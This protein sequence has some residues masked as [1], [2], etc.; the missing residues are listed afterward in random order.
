MSRDPET[1]GMSSCLSEVAEKFTCHPDE[2]ELI[3][4]VLPPFADPV[5]VSLDSGGNGFGQI[6]ASAGR[7]DA[8][9]FGRV[10]QKTAFDEH[11]R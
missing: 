11:G 1:L 7:Y 4:T 5:S 3:L 10:G 2:Q 9:C 6:F 8:G